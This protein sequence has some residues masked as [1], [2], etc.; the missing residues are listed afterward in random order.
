LVSPY[1]SNHT[2]VSHVAKDQKKAVVYAY[3]INPRYG[4]K[5]LPVKLQG[6]EPT[7]TCKVFG[8][9]RADSYGLS[10]MQMQGAM[11]IFAANLKRIFKIM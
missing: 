1:E 2:A 6:L 4:E 5:L 7:K 11:A 10:A 8:Y 3:D 9:D